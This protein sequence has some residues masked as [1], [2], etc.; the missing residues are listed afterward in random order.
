MERGSDKRQ[1]AAGLVPERTFV[2]QLRSDSDLAQRRLCGRVEHLVSGHSEPFV[3]L[4]A[5]LAF[6]SRHAPD[7]P[8][9]PGEDAH[10]PR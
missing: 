7:E 9:S 1:P 4:D 10:G 2:I 6:M 5:L 3:S 8:A